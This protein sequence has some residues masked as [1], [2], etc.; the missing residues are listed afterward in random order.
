ML[1]YVITAYGVTNWLWLIVS[2]YI[3]PLFLGSD[4]LLLIT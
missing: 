1:F 2:V 4:T 3:L